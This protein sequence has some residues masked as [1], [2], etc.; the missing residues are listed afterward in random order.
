NEIS[1]IAF[2]AAG[3]P[4][5]YPDAG[6]PWQPVRLCYIRWS[7]KRMRAM[8]EKFLEMG[9]ES[10]FTGDWL[11]RIVAS[12]EAE[13]TEPDATH[14]VVDTSGFGY[15][16]R[17]GLLAHAT[18]VDPSSRHWFGLPPDIADTVYPFDEYE[19]ARDLTALGN[20]TGILDDL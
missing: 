2:E 1:E 11:G 9:L 20:R 8:H 6:A 3:D 16:L 10:P 12:E 13:Q 18:Q 15:A 14:I 7:V 4:D 19:V 5:R 17:E